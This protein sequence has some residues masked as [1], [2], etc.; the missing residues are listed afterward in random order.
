MD[1]Y[2][3]DLL[4]I[5]EVEPEVSTPPK[6]NSDNDHFHLRPNRR[7]SLNS[8]PFKL[9]HLSPCRSQ[10]PRNLRHTQTL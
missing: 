6:R 10:W 9:T 4:H 1:N 3:N 2:L 8:E 7:N 5:L